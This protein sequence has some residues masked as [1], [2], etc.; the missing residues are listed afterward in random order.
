MEIEELRS[1]LNDILKDAATDNFFSP[2]IEL[3]G[4]KLYREI[5]EDF[6]TLC[7]TVVC[8]DEVEGDR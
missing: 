7:E 6:L 8:M 5:I 2:F 3:L 1:V 4:G